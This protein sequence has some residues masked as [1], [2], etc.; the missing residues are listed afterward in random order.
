MIEDREV[1]RKAECE[2][3][4]KQMKEEKNRIIAQRKLSSNLS[5][6]EDEMRALERALEKTISREQIES[7]H[8]KTYAITKDEF[9]SLDV[10]LEEVIRA[11]RR[12]GA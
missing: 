3:R 2:R 1:K 11:E 10:L 9:K 8:H 4:V 7:D 6:A 5:F 12:S